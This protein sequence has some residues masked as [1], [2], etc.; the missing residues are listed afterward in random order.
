MQ[1][2]FS[3]KC[4]KIFVLDDPNSDDSLIMSEDSEHE[5]HHSSSEDEEEDMPTLI[6]RLQR[7]MIL[8]TIILYCNRNTLFLL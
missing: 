6:N 1:T 2:L 8:S 3:I 7:Y 5:H 4:C